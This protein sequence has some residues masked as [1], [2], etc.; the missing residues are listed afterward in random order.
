MLSKKM[1]ETNHFSEG[2]F[3]SVI[4]SFSPKKNFRSKQDT[5]GDLHSLNST[6]SKFAPK[7]LVQADVHHQGS[8]SK[9]GKR[10]GSTDDRITYNAVLAKTGFLKTSGSAAL[11]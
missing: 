7:L 8:S 11:F 1:L 2:Q 4:S 3:Q 10:N 9:L 5:F 6:Q